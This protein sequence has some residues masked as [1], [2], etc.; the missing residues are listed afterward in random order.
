MHKGY[1]IGI[2]RVHEAIG[3]AS[4]LDTDQYVNTEFTQ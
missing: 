3:C 1:N 4:K 2:A